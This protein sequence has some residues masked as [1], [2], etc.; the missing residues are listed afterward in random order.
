MSGIE[1]HTR[2]VMACEDMIAAISK[3]IEA[4]D[5]CFNRVRLSVARHM[6]RE[7]LRYGKAA[8]RL[9]AGD[10]GQDGYDREVTP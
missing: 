5:F 6:V 9:I 10:I 2:F 1:G 3:E 7:G 8:S 4:M